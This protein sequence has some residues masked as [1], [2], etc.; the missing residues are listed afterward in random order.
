MAPSIMRHLSKAS[1]ES[2]MEEGKLDDI[3]EPPRSR[4]KPTN[5][6]V[7]DLDVAASLLDVDSDFWVFRRFGKLHLF[8]LL[9][10]QSELANLEYALDMHV[11]GKQEHPI[12]DLL[13]RIKA[14]L[15]EYDSALAA[16]A[17]FKSYKE[18][19]THIIKQFRRR[20]A[21]GENDEG[22]LHKILEVLE[23]PPTGP[24]P[25][26]KDLA[27][28]AATDKT[29]THHFIDS[30]HRLRSMFEEKL[31]PDQSKALAGTSLIYSEEKVR[32]AE[33]VFLHL[34]FCILLVVPVVLLSYLESKVWKLVVL[35]IFLAA[36]SFLCVGLL[37]TPNKS[38]LAVVAGYAAILVVFLSG[39]V[40]S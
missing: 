31:A 24:T 22:K 10:I 8:N 36:A 16:Y 39:N 26:L 18:P 2:S 11:S 7:K 6:G 9:H 32:R 35:G 15:V 17:K 1:S 19:E 37:N 5:F 23:I 29:W 20:A 34:S 21:L 40:G 14:A 25:Y 27:S 33:A 12:E 4:R 38:S 28:I 30:H 13:A 3:Y